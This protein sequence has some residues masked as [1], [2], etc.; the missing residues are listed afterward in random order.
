MPPDIQRSARK[1]FSLF[2][3]DPNHPSLFFKRVHPSNDIYSVRVGRAY[4]AL[5]LR[6]GDDYIWFWIGT[7]ADYDRL[8][9]SL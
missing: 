3:H 1:S 2:N 4:R 8:L 9:K 6:E 7:H 5:A